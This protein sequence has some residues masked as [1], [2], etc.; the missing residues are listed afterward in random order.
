MYFTAFLH[1]AVLLHE[2]LQETPE[3]IYLRLSFTPC[4]AAV[5]AQHMEWEPNS[6]FGLPFSF[7]AIT[8]GTLLAHLALSL[9][10][11]EPIMKNLALQGLVRGLFWS[12]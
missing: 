7:M 6:H 12:L 3:R 11:W 5:R 2:L 10:I 8:L 9:L 1:A 4:S